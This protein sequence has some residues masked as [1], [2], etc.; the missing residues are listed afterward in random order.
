MLPVAD[1]DSPDALRER[2]AL[3]RAEG[4]AP[5]RFEGV[6]LPD[7][8]IVERV[9]GVSVRATLDVPE[10]APFF[11]DHFPRRAVF[12]ATLLLDAQ[13]RLAQDLARAAPWRDGGEPHPVRVT[14]VKVRAFTLPGQR[15]ELSVDLTA[16]ADGVAKATLGAR[17]GGR[18]V[19]TARLELATCT[20]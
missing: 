20:S 15:L 16:P 6:R 10:S 2:F 19:A 13:I 5:G 18:N 8:T 7:V 3:L 12:P 17:I 4:A 9:P 11:G 1:F 14:H